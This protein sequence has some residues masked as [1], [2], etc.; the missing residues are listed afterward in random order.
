ME[1]C[2][3]S[4]VSE[5]SPNKIDNKA[6]TLQCQINWS[7]WWVRNFNRVLKDNEVDEEWKQ[8]WWKGRM[9]LR[10]PVET[11]T[12]LHGWPPKKAQN[13]EGQCVR[14]EGMAPTRL[15]EWYSE[16]Q[17]LG[18]SVNPVIVERRWVWHGD[19]EGSSG[20][21][22]TAGTLEW[23]VPFPGAQSTAAD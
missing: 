1:H 21:P 7:T 4:S 15:P 23:P 17:Q 6:E 2:S 16:E 10:A 19:S 8:S 13:P 11:W 9:C 14:K 18:I 5:N 3:T 12:T 20:I 22:Q